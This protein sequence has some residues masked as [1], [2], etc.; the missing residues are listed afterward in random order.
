MSEKE[1]EKPEFVVKDRRSA[2]QSEE[3]VQAGDQEKEQ[4]KTKQAAQE[5]QA[6]AQ[7]ENLEIDF[8]TFIMSLTSS[9]FYHLGDVPDP[10]TGRVEQNLPAVRQTID[11]LTMLQEKTKNNL[12]P[13]ESKLFGQLIYELQ[14]KYVDK[15]K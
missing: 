12:T 5:E 8:S 9:A 3:E 13:Q 14:L 11:I 4:E 15:T 6:G 7:E 1:P 2:F 10:L